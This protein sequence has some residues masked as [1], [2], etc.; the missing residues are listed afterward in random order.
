V[1]WGGIDKVAVP[2]GHRALVLD[3]DGEQP[4]AGDPAPSTVIDLS[5][6]RRNRRLATAA[7]NGV[8]CYE[9]HSGTPVTE[10]PYLG[11]RIALAVA[12]TGRW[13]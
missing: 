8:R 7:S 13:I 1:R 12:P 6:L 3:P 2:S 11:S 9:R 5:W 10:Y 4:W